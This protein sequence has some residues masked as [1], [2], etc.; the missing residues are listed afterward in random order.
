MYHR[1][2]STYHSCI[3]DIKAKNNFFYIKIVEKKLRIFEGSQH[4]EI[5]MDEY[6]EPLFVL[7]W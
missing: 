4:S 5:V 3:Y 2:N 7:I 1:S 6:I